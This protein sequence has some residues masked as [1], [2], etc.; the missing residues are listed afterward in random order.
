MAGERYSCE[1]LPD[2][3]EVDRERCLGAVLTVFEVEP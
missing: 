2:M 3:V 1:T